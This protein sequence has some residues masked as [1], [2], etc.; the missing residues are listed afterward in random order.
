MVCNEFRDDIHSSII[1]FALNRCAM[2]VCAKCLFAASTRNFIRAFYSRQF[3]H[4]SIID[5]ETIL[6]QKQNIYAICSTDCLIVFVFDARRD[7]VLCVKIFVLRHKMYQIIA[8][9]MPKIGHTH[10]HHLFPFFFIAIL[11]LI[12]KKKREKSALP[13]TANKCICQIET[14]MMFVIGIMRFVVFNLT[15]AVFVL[16]ITVCEQS[17]YFDVLAMNVKYH[18][19]LYKK[20]LPNESLRGLHRANEM[21]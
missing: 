13:L 15:V 4:I 20:I 8:G 19:V 10:T 2:C 12:I 14:E 5:Q 18:Y 11:F 9:I 16:Q 7:S 1:V 3:I 17:F 6:V 21:D